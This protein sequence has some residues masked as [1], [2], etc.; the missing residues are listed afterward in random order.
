[1]K[2]WGWE[3]RTKKRKIICHGITLRE[4]LSWMPNVAKLTPVS[5]GTSGGFVTSALWKV[6]T[7]N[8]IAANEMKYDI[9][10]IDERNKHFVVFN[11]QI[12]YGIC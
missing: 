10:C 8:A 5:S 1:M 9:P 4:A 11:Y 3:R 2:K 7:K 6:T 12:A